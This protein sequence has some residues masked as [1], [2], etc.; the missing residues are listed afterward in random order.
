MS[1]GDLFV[2]L[3]QKWTFHDHESELCE[4]LRSLVG[5]VQTHRLNRLSPSVFALAG[6][7][8]CLFGNSI[9]IIQLNI[10]DTMRNGNFSS[11]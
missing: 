5:S 8:F 3:T 11:F 4:S 7:A 6:T 2:P 9:H 10:S 1:P